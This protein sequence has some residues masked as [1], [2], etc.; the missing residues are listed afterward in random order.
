LTPPVAVTLIEF[1]EQ[2]SSVVMLLFIIPAVGTSSSFV[3]VMLVL[4]VQPLAPVT[5]T[6]YVP[7]APKLLFA[8]DGVAPPFHESLTP[9]VA[10]TLIEVRLH[11]SSSVP[12]LLVIAA[13]G[14]TPSVIIAL[15]VITLL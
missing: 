4:A 13:I 7:G 10:V 12:V 5:T 1:V 15:P 14:N 11:V 2:F 8:L 3:M 9:P 6:V